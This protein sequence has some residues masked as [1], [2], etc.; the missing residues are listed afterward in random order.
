M[1]NLF[2][3]WWT[4]TTG[5]LSASISVFTGVVHPVSLLATLGMLCLL[6]GLALV[7]RWREPKA[8]NM[9]VPV[10]MASLTPVVLGLANAV[11]SWVGVAFSLFAGTVVLVLL[12]ALT[13]RD[14]TRRLPI[15]LIGVFA[16]TY[17]AFSALLA[18]AEIIATA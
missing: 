8:I 17:A 13:A 2:A 9:L 5:Y 10:A 14:A 1:T 7:I 15:W 11:L 16:L 6:V 12:I 18:I 4:A 3:S